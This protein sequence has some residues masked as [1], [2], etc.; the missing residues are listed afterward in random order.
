VSTLVKPHALAS[1]EQ[2]VEGMATEPVDATFV[3]L[4]AARAVADV[5]TALACSEEAS[6]RTDT[7]AI[8]TDVDGEVDKVEEDSGRRSCA[9]N[10]VHEDVAVPQSV[11]TPMETSLNAVSK[12]EAEQGELAGTDV[13]SE[14]FVCRLAALRAA[15]SP[16][17]DIATDQAV[18]GVNKQKETKD[19]FASLSTSLAALCKGASRTRR[20]GRSRKGKY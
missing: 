16:L 3:A 19:L 18:D 6:P 9:F 1:A 14:E 2:T 4:A 7:D 20:N 5:K 12:F 8:D 10:S 11:E 15:L 17:V 13:K